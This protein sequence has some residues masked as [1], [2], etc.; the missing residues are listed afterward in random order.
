MGGDDGFWDNIVREAVL[1]F[2]RASAPGPSGLRPAHL[3]DALRR[4]GGG[5]GLIRSL[6]R[7]VTKWVSGAL[8]IA[9]SPYLCGANLTP[10]KKPDGGVRPVAVGETLR[11]LVGK[12]LLSSGV[13]KSQVSSLAPLQVGVGIRSA[14]E[15]VAIG[16]QSLVDHL[17]PTASWC[18]LK[19]DMANAFNTVDRTALLKASLHYTPSVY[20]Y[21]RFAYGTDVPLHL[22]NGIKLQSRTG[23]HQGC[24]L[25]P[26]GFALAIH[27]VVEK[28][29]REAGL[30]WNSWYL[31][32]GLLV[33]SPDAVSK[34]FR[35]LKDDLGAIGLHVNQRKCEVWGP[36]AHLFL[37]AHEGVAHTPWEPATGITVLGIPV[38]Y[39]E[40][41]AYSKALWAR[42]NE[43]LEMTVQMVTSLVDAQ[44]AHHLLRMCLDGCKVNHLLRACDCYSDVDEDVRHSEGVVL[45]AFADI[46]G[47]AMKP[48]QMVQ[49]GLP[50]AV[51]GCGLRC[52]TVMKPAARLAALATFYSRGAQDVGLPT[53]CRHVVARWVLPPVQEAMGLIGPNFDPLT[54]WSGNVSAIATA[55][56]AHLIQKWWSENIGKAKLTRLLDS[57][58]PRDQARLLEQ[59]NSVTGSFM[60][61]APNAAIRSL[62]PSSLYRLGLRWWLGCPLLEAV[63]GDL[64]CPG[65]GMTVDVFGDHLLCCKRNNFLHRHTALQEGLA[66]LLTESGQSFTKE[67][68]IPH[69]PDGQLR[70]A[71]ILLPGWDNGTDTALDVTLVHGWQASMQSSNVSRERWRSFLRVK[72]RLKHQRYDAACKRAQWSFKALAM[73]TWGGMGPEGARVFHRILKRAAFWLEGDLRA[74]RQEELKQ[75]FGL[76]VIRH[77]WRLLD[78]KNMIC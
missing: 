77:V 1:H 3:Q 15:M 32:D 4:R 41:Q 76:A 56:G 48:S 59:G 64:K 42:I 71:D 17:G 51:G 67:V 20:N 5:L 28:L 40:S 63:D 23:T 39:P 2:P 46:L 34:A 36:A 29:Q 60:S 25:G 58:S 31:D 74:E 44:L 14:A 78:A 57:V 47:C 27:P 6:A 50:I 13:A 70:P 54:E 49:A 43:R 45:D 52:P 62:I 24:P 10:L 22:G 12:A 68:A 21:L 38:C 30:V 73:G 37:A 16:A 35:I 33:G 72:E 9:H 53:Y 55:Q 69:C 75:S 66:V 18:I 7:L 26:L 61:V 11:R 65:C 8:P 19:V